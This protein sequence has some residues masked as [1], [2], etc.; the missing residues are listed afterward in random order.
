MMILVPCFAICDMC[1]QANYGLL[2]DLSDNDKLIRNRNRI[3]DERLSASKNGTVFQSRHA[4]CKVKSNG[5]ADIPPE[6]RKCKEYG[7]K[8]KSDPVGKNKVHTS[9]IKSDWKF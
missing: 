5:T 9:N 4:H 8:D 3:R 1:A 2:C 7:S 6:T